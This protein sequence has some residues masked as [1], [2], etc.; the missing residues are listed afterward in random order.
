MGITVYSVIISIVFFN[1]ALIAAFLMRRSNAF[2]A[3]HTVSFLLLMV[4]L[5]IVRLLTP[6]DFD[7]AYVVRSY[8]VIPAIEDFVNRPIAG[9]YTRGS[10]LQLIWLAGTIIF[11]VRDIVAQIRFVHISRNYPP[12]DRRDLIDLAGAYGSNFGLLV[13]SS[14]S[15]PYT[16]GLFRPTI[17]LPDI[18]LPEESWR[19]ILRHEVQHIHSHDEAKKLFF[20]AIQALFWWNPLAHISRKEIDTLLELQCDAKV[21]V[22]MSKEEVAA[23]LKLLMTLKDRKADHQLPIGASTLLWDQKQLEARFTALHT[24]DSSGK[25]ASHVAVFLLLLATFLMSYFIIIQPAGFASEEKLIEDV[26]V[27]DINTINADS[28][29]SSEMYIVYENNEYHLYVNGIATSVV[30]EE[31]LSL[32]PF[33]TLP[34]LEEN[35]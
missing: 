19:T 15:R 34:I 26:I 23:Y 24:A 2:L 35:K 1:I 4:V 6:I 18:E 17:Y 33:N 32:P 3:G 5:G 12:S 10:L 9:N 27:S 13:S 22:G 25:P 21:T 29:Y 28:A 8:Q 31:S 30:S 14:I 7:S 11:F 16:A 20:L